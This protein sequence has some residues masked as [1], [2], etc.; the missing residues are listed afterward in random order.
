MKR[1]LT[2]WLGQPHVTDH[3]FYYPALPSLFLS[4]SLEGIDKTS[5]PNPGMVFL[6]SLRYVHQRQGPTEKPVWLLQII[7]NKAQMMIRKNSA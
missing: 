6:N 1:I 3:P 2:L 4:F 7:S 5:T